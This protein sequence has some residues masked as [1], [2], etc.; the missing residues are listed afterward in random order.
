MIVFRS[1]FN[2]YIKQKISN[3]F[4][5]SSLKFDQIRKKNKLNQ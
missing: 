1:N 4:Q 5:F 3:F 2:I